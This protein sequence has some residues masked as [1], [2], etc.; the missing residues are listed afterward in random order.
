M[1]VSLDVNIVLE[2]CGTTTPMEGN[3]VQ[4]FF[5]WK[6]PL[7]VTDFIN[8]MWRKPLKHVTMLG[9]LAE[10]LSRKY[11]VLDVKLVSPQA[12]KK[13]S[14]SGCTKFRTP[15]HR[16]NKTH[17]SSSHSDQIFEKPCWP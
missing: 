12:L 14:N 8:T 4:V 17:M 7:K 1:L 2:P 11:T 5:P 6:G 13:R 16:T 10:L 15:D 3:K 9:K